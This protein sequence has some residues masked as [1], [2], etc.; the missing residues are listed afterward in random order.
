MYKGIA[1]V[2]YNVTDYDRA[3]EFYCGK[4]GF[5]K[6]VEMYQDGKLW[7]QYLRVAP[8]Q[9]IEIFPDREYDPEAKPSYN[10]LSV[11]VTDMKSHR[12]DLLKKGVEVSEI[13]KGIDGNYQCWITDP[14]GNRIELM[15][16]MPDGIQW[17]AEEKIGSK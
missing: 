16:L 6:H 9:Y 15:E 10:H 7:I 3:M 2:A 14:D 1:H 12:D 13:V 4:L 8:F 5:T 17:Q 11:A